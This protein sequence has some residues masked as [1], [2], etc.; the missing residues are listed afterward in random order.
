MS[1][2]LKGQKKGVEAHR[3]RGVWKDIPGLPLVQNGW[4]GEA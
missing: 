3:R 2:R 4:I 1:R